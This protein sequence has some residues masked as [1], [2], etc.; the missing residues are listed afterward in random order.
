MKKESRL[1]RIGGWIALI[2]IILPGMIVSGFMPEWN[3]LPFHL[4]LIIAT[5]GGALGGALAVEKRIP[6]LI[7]GALVGA[8][9]LFGII[10]YVSIRASLTGNNT[11]LKIE[12]A[13]GA[14]IGAIPG[15]LVY[16]FVAR[17]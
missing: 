6:G 11:F 13:L 16:Y 8:G 1:E 4:W 2:A 3:V 10:T 5:L 9:A 17:D 14:L 7:S 15:L 12:L